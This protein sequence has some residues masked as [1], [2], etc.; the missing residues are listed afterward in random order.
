[1]L[2]F[3]EVQDGYVFVLLGK[4]GV[5]KSTFANRIYGDTSR[6]ADKGPAQTSSSTV[7]CTTAPEIV[8]C[9]FRNKILHV[10]D[11]GGFADTEGRDSEH[12]NN[13]CEFLNGCGGINAFVLLL[14]SQEPRMTAET[15]NALL[16]YEKIFGTVM[17][18]QLVV[19]A[20]R[21]DK[22]E[23][24]LDYKEDNTEKQLRNSIATKLKLHEK[25]LSQGEIATLPVIPIGRQH[26]KPALDQVSTQLQTRVQTKFG[27][28]E[29]RS[30]LNQLQSGLN[31]L[32]AEY[33]ERQSALE[34]CA[35]AAA[36][37]GREVDGLRNALDTVQPSV[38]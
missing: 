21:V 12:A 5:G 6:R 36:S 17:Y 28:T 19:V 26:Y 38:K 34:D 9:N 24:L 10:V 37:L 25:G 16:E 29:L 22:G 4:T 30:P 2:N 20:T 27:T 33:K 13:L 32:M 8:K 14:N 18:K 7:S 11:S 23:N 35:Q 1:M 3:K 15:I 31:E